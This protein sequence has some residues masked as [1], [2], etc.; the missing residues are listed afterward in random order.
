MGNV[1]LQ[2]SRDHGICFLLHDATVLPLFTQ[3]LLVGTCPQAGDPR[4][5]VGLSYLLCNP[6]LYL[7]SCTQWLEVMWLQVQTAG[8]ALSRLH[9]ERGVG[10]THSEPNCTHV[11]F[12]LPLGCSML[13]VSDLLS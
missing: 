13:I 7:G 3:D 2:D 12:H 9:Q 10:V 6:R 8:V 4:V 11:L 5:L 1:W